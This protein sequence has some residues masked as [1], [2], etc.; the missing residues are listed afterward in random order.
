MS[1]TDLIPASE[2]KKSGVSLKLVVAEKRGTPKF[3]LSIPTKLSHI[4]KLDGKGVERCRVQLGSA[5]N[6][7]KLRV[8]FGAFGSY[9]IARRKHVCNVVFP[10]TPGVRIKEHDDIVAS[11]ADGDGFIFTLPDWAIPSGGNGDT[12]KPADEKPGSVEINGKRLIMGSKEA[13]LSI[14]GAAI[15]KVLVHHF[16]EI[17]ARE[18]LI[19]AVSQTDKTLTPLAKDQLDTW[20][21]KLRG[22]IDQAEMDLRIA[23]HARQGFSL[24]RSTA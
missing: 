2:A 4:Y 1:W 3:I 11:V 6:A 12:A 21:M 5:E 14:A 23:V 20:V 19:E 22:A 17:V 16:G 13:T 7:G 8:E 24:M 9:K 18:K 15:A 10:V